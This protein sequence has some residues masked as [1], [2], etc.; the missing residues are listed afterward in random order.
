[1]RFSFALTMYRRMRRRVRARRRERQARR[2]I[3]PTVEPAPKTREEL[4][5]L[6]RVYPNGFIC[7]PE[8]PSVYGFDPEEIEQR[9][10][11]AA[12]G[13]TIPADEFFN[14]IR[15]RIRAGRDG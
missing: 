9:R 5:D 6:L 2:D 1:M 13:H 3:I 15:A 8:D 12:A 4:L 7:F 11:A 10:I 14:G